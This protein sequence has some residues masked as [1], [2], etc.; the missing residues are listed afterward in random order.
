MGRG[1]SRR[2]WDRDDWTRDA[3]LTD[4]QRMLVRRRSHGSRIAFSVILI[5]AGVLLFLANLGLFPIENIW[6]FWPLFPIA[7]GIGRLLGGKDPRTQF[8]GVLLVLFGGLFVLSNLGWIHWRTTNGS[9][10]IALI[11]I[12]VGCAALFGVVESAGRPRAAPSGASFLGSRQAF[13]YEKM[14]NDYVVFGNLKRKLETDDFRGGDLTTIFG[15]IEI[16]LRRAFITPLAR[17]AVINVTT[18]FGETKIRVPE[19]WRVT[20]SGVSILGS[21]EDKTIPPNSGPDAP[22]LI[23]TGFSVFGS[24]SIED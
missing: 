4:E 15:N 8:V 6:I 11:L 18:V 24:A 21:F 10:P 7:A 9:W 14:I 23:V 1:V 12:G 5:A 2:R 22:T 16:D 17:S 3:N 13:S 19:N 20:V